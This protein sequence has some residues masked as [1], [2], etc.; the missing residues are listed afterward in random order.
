MASTAYNTLNFDL[1][2]TDYHTT[3]AREGMYKNLETDERYIGKPAGAAR[4]ITIPPG[5]PLF[6]FAPKKD[7]DYKWDGAWWTTKLGF[8]HV[9]RRAAA[10]EAAVPM[11]GIAPNL[12]I[13]NEARE[14]SNVLKSWNDM[15]EIGWAVVK[16]DRYV[17]CFMGFGLPKFTHDEH[18]KESNIQLCIPNLAPDKKS[19]RDYYFTQIRRCLVRDFDV[20]V[21]N[22]LSDATLLSNSYLHKQM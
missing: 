3:K 1:K 6:R 16:P 5:Q 10:K 14:Y 11:A 15:D 17:K 20:S 4:V 2:V 12:H 19:Q 7:P 21:L 8:F 9:L 18:Y 22:K 13:T